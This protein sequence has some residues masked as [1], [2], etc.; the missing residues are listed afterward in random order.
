MEGVILNN[1]KPPG[2]YLIADDMEVYFVAA[3]LQT[4]IDMCRFLFMN[5]I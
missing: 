4:P 2:Y 1:Y 3:S 5:R